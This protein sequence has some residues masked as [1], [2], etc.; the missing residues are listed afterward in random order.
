MSL[1]FLLLVAGVYGGVA[2]GVGFAE[3]GPGGVCDD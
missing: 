3:A 2:G 1:L